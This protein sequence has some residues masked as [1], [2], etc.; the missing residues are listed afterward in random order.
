[1]LAR[2]LAG[3]CDVLIRAPGTTTPQIQELH[4]PIYHGLCLAVEAERYA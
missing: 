2:Q 1:M 3:L 4:L